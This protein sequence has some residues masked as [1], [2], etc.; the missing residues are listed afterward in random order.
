MLCLAKDCCKIQAWWTVG[1]SLSIVKFWKY[2]IPYFSFG[3]CDILALI[4]FLILIFYDYYMFNS[5]LYTGCSHHTKSKISSS[6]ST[7]HIGKAISV[8][9]LTL[10]W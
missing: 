1:W 5:L 7:S 10:L 3:E 2:K 6:K 4:T 9:E 8:L